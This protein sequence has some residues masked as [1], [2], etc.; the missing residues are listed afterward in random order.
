MPLRI[1]SC[2][3]WNKCWRSGSTL[4]LHY[5]LGSENAKADTLS[6]RYSFIPAKPNQNTILP[7]LCF[8]KTLIRVIDLS[9][10]HFC[11]PVSMSLPLHTF[12]HTAPANGH[13][14]TQH[15][16]CTHSSRLSSGGPICL[17][18]LTSMHNFCIWLYNCLIYLK[19]IV[20]CIDFEAF[21]CPHC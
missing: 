19:S 11:F 2:C 13:P 6:Q 12:A 5:R 9:G 20:H 10:V 4:S 8:L 17:T 15:T 1:V 21:L 14:V 3:Q 16:Y 18:T 7:P